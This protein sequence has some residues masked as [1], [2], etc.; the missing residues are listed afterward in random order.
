MHAFYMFINFCEAGMIYPQFTNKELS[1]VT[2]NNLLLLT[3]GDKAGISVGMGHSSLS[4]LVHIVFRR[5]EHLP[6]VRIYKQVAHR[7]MQ[8]SGVLSLALKQ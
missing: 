5:F 2:L 1:S 6:A 7:Y 3:V 8:L 4:P